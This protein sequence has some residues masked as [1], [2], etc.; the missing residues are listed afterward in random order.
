MSF[1]Q[2]EVPPPGGWYWWR[3]QPDAPAQPLWSTS[4]RAATNGQW[5]TTPIL[6]P[7]GT[8]RCMTR[9]ETEYRCREAESMHSLG[10][11]TMPP[12]FFN[13]LYGDHL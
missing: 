10:P 11:F 5:W 2:S 3:P 9:E 4:F 8:A 7:P 12:G 6:E 1:W 13:E